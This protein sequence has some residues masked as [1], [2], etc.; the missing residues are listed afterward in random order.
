MDGGE[1]GSGEIGHEGALKDVQLPVWMPET[2]PVEPFVRLCHTQKCLDFQAGHCES[3]KPMQCFN[4]HFEGQ[5]RR[6][7]IGEDGRL[8]YWDTPCEWLARPARCPHGESCHFAHSKD[9]VSYHPAKYKTRACNGKDCRKAICCFAHGDGELRIAAPRLYSR[10]ALAAAAGL[11]PIAL[12]AVHSET[13]EALGLIDLTTFKVFPCKGG[14][15]LPHDRKVCTFFHNP[16]DRRRAPGSYAAEP[17]PESFDVEATTRSSRCSRG[18]KCPQCHNRLELLYHPDVYKRRF[19]STYPKISACQRGAQCAFAH[20]R[21][22]I[23]AQI[24]TKSEEEHELTEGSGEMFYMHRFKTLWCP[25]SVPHDWHRCVYAHTY[26]DWRRAPEL[27]YDSEPCTHW[28][29]THAPQTSYQERCPN[30][31]RCPFSHGSKEQLY[32]PMY[33]KTMPCL[34]WAESRD[35]PRRFLCAFFH[36]ADERRVLKTT[37]S[38]KPAVGDLLPDNTEVLASLQRGF[39][40]PPLFGA[41]SL[42]VPETASCGGLAGQGVREVFLGGSLSSPGAMASCSSGAPSACSLTSVRTSYNSLASLST[43]STSPPAAPAPPPGPAML[44]GLEGR[45]K[46]LPDA[47]DPNSLPGSMDFQIAELNSLFAL[48]LFAGAGAAGRLGHGGYMGGPGMDVA[49]ATAVAAAMAA[50]G[51]GGPVPIPHRAGVMTEGPSPVAAAATAAVAKALAA[52]AWAQ[53]AQAQAQQQCGID[54]MWVGSREEA[55]YQAT[56]LQAALGSPAY[57]RPLAPARF[58]AS[59]DTRLGADGSLP[60]AR[61]PSSGSSRKLG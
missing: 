15:N 5:R 47:V 59:S 39:Q 7:P 51:F 9:E 45:D 60:S 41:E 24:L 61:P 26:Q 53:A 21:E 13:G 22:E 4:Y 38:A 20:A 48:Q 42:G 30:G 35:C 19:C 10:A 52:N 33:Y 8:T 44:S 36:D 54:P 16:R 11:P 1:A 14:R 56:V 57:V 55:P 6:P 43:E 49:A 27:G 58:G 18:D 12:G 46:Q 40:R 31:F 17:C 3:H 37:A 29:R 32:H 50:R 25:Y 2:Q 23:N 34:D 28:S